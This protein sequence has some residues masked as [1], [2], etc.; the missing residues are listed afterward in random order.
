MLDDPTKGEE[1]TKDPEGGEVN[2]NDPQTGDAAGTEQPTG[3]DAQS[4]DPSGSSTVNRSKYDADIRRRDKTIAELKK[5]LAELT[6]S[7]AASGDETAKLRAD[8]EAYKAQTTQEKL[9]LKL[10]AAGCVNTKAAMALLDDYDGDVTKLA[11]DCPYLFKTEKKG[12]ST[13]LKPT[14]AASAASALDTR[15]R[16]SAGLKAKE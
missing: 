10:S 3:E 11:A 6:E 9:E 1:T 16:E 15:I 2:T 5:Q 14:G 4:K 7:K 12:G 8:F 13:G